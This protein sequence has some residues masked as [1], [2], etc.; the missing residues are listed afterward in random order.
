MADTTNSNEKLPV[1]KKTGKFHYNPGNMAG[2]KAE[3]GEDDGQQSA[4]NKPQNEAAVKK[5]D[6]LPK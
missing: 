3:P 5:S 2:K 4:S 1:E 6:G